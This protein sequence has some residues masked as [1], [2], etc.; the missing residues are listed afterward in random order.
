MHIFPNNK[1]YIGVTRN[2]LDKRFG[3]N[4]SQYQAKRIKN[5]IQKYGWINIKHI[6]LED[7]LSYEDAIKLESFYIDMY[8]TNLKAFGYNKNRGGGFARTQKS[9]NHILTPKRIAWYN[10][11]RNSKRSKEACESCRKGQLNLLNRYV[12][13]YDLQNQLVKKWDSNCQIQ[14][15]LGFNKTFIGKTCKY[16]INN[17]KYRTAYGFIWRY[18]KKD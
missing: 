16:N 5:A 15:E 9:Y 7:K 10:K 4:G 1:K 12:C 18:E 8:Q 17:T 3:K 14:R 13:Q 2:K 6:I 11:V